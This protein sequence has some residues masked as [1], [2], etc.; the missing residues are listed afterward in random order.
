MVMAWT[1]FHETYIF[2]FLMKIA[3]K[4]YILDE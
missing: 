3:M 2:V 4:I 1:I